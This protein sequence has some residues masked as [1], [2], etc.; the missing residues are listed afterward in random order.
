MHASQDVTQSISFFDTGQPYMTKFGDGSTASTTPAWTSISRNLLINSYRSVWPIDHDD[1]SAF[2]K[3]TSN[4]LVY[5]GFKSFLGNNKTAAH[6]LYLFPDAF[7]KQ[8]DANFCASVWQPDAG[9]E[10]WYNNTCVKLTHSPVYGG[11]VGCNGPQQAVTV[12]S[13]NT[14]FYLV[15]GADPS[16][17]TMMVCGNDNVSAVV[18]YDG[19]RV[20]LSLSGSLLRL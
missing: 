4:V 7:E 14:F 3:D 6:N 15:A 2:Y 5:G 12:T 13:N 8:F 1:G 9:P 10:S 17:E 19:A 11:A 20:F 18:M 16:Q